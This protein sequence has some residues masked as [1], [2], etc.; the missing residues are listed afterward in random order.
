MIRLRTAAL[1]LTLAVAA[2]LSAQEATVQEEQQTF[3]TYP[4]SGPDPAPIMTRS[5]MW[6]SGASLYPYYFFDELSLNGVSQER[7]IIRLENAYLKLLVS[8]SDGGKLLAAI[9]KSTG[10][11]FIYFNKVRK[12]R[13]IAHRGPWTSGGIEWNF[14]LVGHTPATASPVDYMIRKNADGSVTCVVGTMDLPSRT[15]WR[16]SITLPPDK[17][18]FLTDALW[19][20]PQPLE[21]SYYVWMNAA[22]KLGQDLEFILPGTKYIAHDYSVPTEPWPLLPD[23]RSL[24]LYKDHREADEGGSY[25]VHGKLQEANGAYWHDSKFG[26]GHWAL[27]EEVPGQKFFRWPLSR[28]GAMWENLLTDSDGPYFEPQSGRLLDQ[29]DHEFF[30]AYTTDRWRE[31]WFPY[32]QIGPMVTATPAGVLNAR[33]NGH[34]VE[35]GFSAL[36]KTDEDL[37]V[38]N[39]DKEVS[40]E[41]LRLAPMGVFE[42][43]L[44]VEIPNGSLR[45]RLGQQQIYTDDPQD[46]LLKRP[47]NFHN[48]DTKTLEGLYQSAERAEKSRDYRT[49]LNQYLECIQRDPTSVRALTRLAAVYYRRAEYAKALEYARR[50]LDFVMYD[51]D[52]NY[53]YALISRRLGDFV[54]AKETLG[55]AA[56]SMKYRSSAYCELAEIYLMEGNFERADEYLRRSLEY[57]AH[58][59]KTLEVLSTLARRTGKK[60]QARTTLA[61]IL[62]IDPLSHLARFETYLLQPDA[63]TLK[64][65]RSM[66][67]NEMPHESYLEIASYYVNLG[68]DEDALRLLEVAPDQAEIRYWQAYLLRN[69][70]AEQSRKVL[71]TA[72]SLSPYLVFPFR[73][74]AIPVFQWAD[75]ALSGNWKAKYYLGLIEWGLRREDDARKEFAAAGNLPDYA[76]FYASRAYLEQAAD[77]AQAQADYERARAVDPKDW[78]NSKRLAAYYASRGMHDKALAVAESA[79]TQFPNEDAIKVTLARAYMNSGHYRECHA[80]L[81]HAT[82][83]PA[84]GQSDVYKLFADCQLALALEAMKQNRYDLAVE[85]IEGSKIYPEHLGTGK[86][87]DPDYRVQDC[88]LTICYQKTN[89]GAKV[90]ERKAAINDFASRNSRDGWDRLSPKLDA[91]YASDFLNSDPLTALKK[92]ATALRGSRA[93]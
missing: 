68:L 65:F 88:L 82:I 30:A 66:I 45:V 5:S 64:N 86:P 83:L 50:A 63:S 34:E 92:L 21:Q 76:A 15:E 79:S 14:G 58:N 8:P 4:F 70:S 85:H 80:T 52:A 19:Y 51:P 35:L 72:A 12:Y 89:Q 18:Y 46:G 56:R 81:E 1:L 62:D 36:Q 42:K 28:D 73:Q 48:Y 9:E 29:N 40:R 27:H 22:A 26:Y 78:R 24:A 10:K 49:A 43:K 77:P 55:W 3:K 69:K 13:D 57:D 71:Q 75:Q 16:V 20:N 74:E 60:E 47:L 87:A 6:G 23:G 33:T 7:N 17:A 32:K 39:G 31:F 54:D 91:W 25:F 44:A 67:R 59:I 53:F 37:V 61:R 84:E 41:H 38:L 93:E 2:R 11:D 90:D